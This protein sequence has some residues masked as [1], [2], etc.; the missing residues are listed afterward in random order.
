ME[1]DFIRNAHEDII[2][3]FNRKK[4]EIIFNLE[5]KLVEMVRERGILKSNLFAA[6]KDR[7]LYIMEAV[8]LIQKY[9]HQSA[10]SLMLKL[11]M[12]SCGQRKL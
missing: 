1:K 12:Q 2:D 10:I 6:L 3:K 11:R 8:V 4:N 5:R 7:I 9:R